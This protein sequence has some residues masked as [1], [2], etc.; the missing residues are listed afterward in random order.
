MAT[1]LPIIP[2]AGRSCE[3]CAMCCKLGTI[4][5]VGKPDGQ[6]CKHCSTRVKCD[7]YETRPFVCRDY[8]CAYMLS[9]L[10]EDWRPTKSKLMVSSMY[11]GSIYVMV[12]PSR[13]DAWKQAPY[14]SLIVKWSEQRRVL[15]FVGLKATAV[16]PT[17]VEELGMIDEKYA[18]RVIEE[19]TPSGTVRRTVRVP[20][21]A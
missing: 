6:W 18:L 14:H 20:K 19:T 11:D 3:G 12:D 1:T 7:I 8:Y 17:H 16:Y 15:V 4:E 21:S 9:D 13:P 2:V 5:E 10:S